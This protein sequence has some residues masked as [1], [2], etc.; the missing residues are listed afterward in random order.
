MYKYDVTG[1]KYIGRC[2]EHRK[3]KIPSHKRNSTAVS[4]LDRIVYSVGLRRLLT[5]LNYM[6]GRRT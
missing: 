3:S 5:K 4:K 6:I 1:R 2:A